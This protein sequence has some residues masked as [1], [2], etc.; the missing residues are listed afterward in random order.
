MPVLRNLYEH[1]KKELPK[2]GQRTKKKEAKEGGEQLTEERPK[3]PRLV[4]GAL[5]QF[6]T[7][8]EE[9]A[10][11]LRERGEES[12]NLFS[13]PPVFIAVCNN[14]SVSKEVY[15]FIAGYEYDRIIKADKKGNLSNSSRWLCRGYTPLFEL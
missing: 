6:Y 8:Y 1:V 10:D 3:L 12:A 5:D 13:R 9:Y 11:N 14:T 15:K 2:K 7:H 4:K